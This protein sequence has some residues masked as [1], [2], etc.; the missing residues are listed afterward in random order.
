VLAS[1]SRVARRVASPEACA[2]AER[3]RGVLSERRAALDL[4]ARGADP[5]GANPALDRALA[6]GARIDTWARQPP[7]VAVPWPDSL[8]RLAAALDQESPS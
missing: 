6:I 8:R 4:Q 2:L 5:P 7:D 1:A 3:A